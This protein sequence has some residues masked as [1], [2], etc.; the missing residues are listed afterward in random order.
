[1]IVFAK[2]DRHSLH[3]VI[4]QRASLLRPCRTEILTSH[5]RTTNLPLLLLPLR[6]A[7]RL[8]QAG[9]IFRQSGAVCFHLGLSW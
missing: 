6:R 7:L 1:M 2:N 3:L 8:L 5:T 4:I 9:V